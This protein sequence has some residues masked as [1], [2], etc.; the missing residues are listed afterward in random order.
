[1]T[2]ARTS[3]TDAS[4]R[5]RADPAQFQ[6]VRRRTKPAPSPAPIAA[7]AD[8]LADDS[9]A[10][11]TPHSSSMQNGNSDEL[12][13]VQLADIVEVLTEALEQRD[14]AIEAMTVLIAEQRAAIE[15]INGRL[16][17]LFAPEKP[18]EGYIALRKAA[19]MIKKSDEYLRVRAARGEIDA[20]IISDKWFVRI[21]ALAIP[22][23]NGE[24]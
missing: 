14:R 10:D 6:F 11:S 16:D 23:E 18:R 3:R 8:Q 22:N 4:P 19:A 12:R 13:P 24:G 2:A 9:L 5:A 1:M 21:G 17:R 7:G 15:A 20:Q